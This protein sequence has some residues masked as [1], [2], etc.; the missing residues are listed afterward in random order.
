[1]SKGNIYLL[2]LDCEATGLSKYSDQITEIGLSIYEYTSGDGDGG[3]FRELESFREYARPTIVKMTRGALVVTG[4]TNEFLK[5]KSTIDV[6]L[7]NMMVHI[8]KVCMNPNVERC[9]VA[10]NG[11]GYDLPLIVAELSRFTQPL[12]YFRRL[13]LSQIV[14]V[15]YWSKERLDTTY[16]VRRSNGQCSYK[17]GDVYKVVCGKKLVGAHGALVDCRAVVDMLQSIPFQPFLTDVLK[18]FCR[19]S[20][21]D[22]RPTKTRCSYLVNPISFVRTCVNTHD[23]K[24]NTKDRNQL[25]IVDM[26]QHLNSTKR[27]CNRTNDQCNKKQKR[28]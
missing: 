15:L 12:Q 6:V 22:E 28:L 18:P 13:R 5:D 16:L 26:L 2:S 19:P 27:K 24:K 4:I 20:L 17:L 8:N 23:T 14:D 25:S 11:I 3:T 9:L 7:N 10:Y 1:M 21:N